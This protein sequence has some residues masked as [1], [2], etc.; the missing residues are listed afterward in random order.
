MIT[1]L[2]NGD[3]NGGNVMQM[4]KVS[5]PEIVKQFERLFW[6][7]TPKNW[8]FKS[9]YTRG[10]VYISVLVEICPR[11]STIQKYT[12]KRRNISIN[13]LRNRS[14][15]IWGLARDLVDEIKSDFDS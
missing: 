9:V 5:R 7:N 12:K 10:I 13:V 3:R 4:A 8:I 11:G 14:N 2:T 15:D 6:A 1:I